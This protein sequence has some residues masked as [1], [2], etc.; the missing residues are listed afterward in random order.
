MQEENLK[1]EYAKS[2][3][4]DEEGHFVPVE[5]EK[6][7]DKESTN[8]VVRFLHNET[9]I[10]KSKDDE[11]LDIH[12]G[13]P[14][15]RITDLLEQIKRQKAFSFTLK[16]SLGIMGV[17][18]VAGTFS[19]LGGSK[20]LCDKGTQ[21]KIGEVRELVYKENSERSFLSY[22]PFLESFFPDRK[23][24]RKILIDS[25]GKVIHII[26]KNDVDF[27]TTNP[28]QKTLTGNYDSCSETL[29]VDD[30]TG[31]QEFFK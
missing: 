31:V 17:A 26:G 20:A 10:H 5:D 13:N 16:G 28:Q 18:L 15:R 11:L 21:T 7:D 30:Q 29:R 14:L 4:R 12:I 22:V 23:I 6:K 3:P 8:P 24:P 27:M 2:R 9:A 19:I 25:S 1:S